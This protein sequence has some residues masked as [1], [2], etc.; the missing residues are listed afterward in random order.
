MSPEEMK[1]LKELIEQ[2]GKLTAEL[3][4]K[5]DKM[6][7]DVVHKD[8]YKK[9]EAEVAKVAKDRAELEAKHAA[10]LAE[11]KALAEEAATKASRRGLGADDDG[12]PTEAQREHKSAFLNWVRHSND[13]KA[14]AA[15]QDAEK[16]AV[17]ISTPGTGGY[18]VPEE[19]SRMIQSKV[20]NEAVMRGLVNVVSVGTSDY[21]ELVDKTG[22][23]VG[24]TGETGT[25]SETGTPA[26]YEVAPPMGEIYAY[27]KAS[28]WSLDD[29]FFNVEEWLM[30]HVGIGFATE[31]DSVVISGSGTNRP[32][33]LLNRAPVATADGARADQTLQYVPT[34]AAGAFGADEHA[35][36]VNLM[37]TLRSG[38]RR[39]ASWLMNSMTTAAVRI[40]KDGNG[41]P[42]WQ[43]NQVA[44]Q[45]PALMGHSV[46]ICEAMPDI[47]ADALAIGFG[48]WARTYTLVDRVGQRMTRDDVTQPGYV[49]F[50]VR[51]R[52]GGDVT[53]DDAAK[54]LKFALS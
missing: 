47:A 26:I 27:P 8:E 22:A 36:L 9:L 43:D 44:G 49:K 13:H 28:E 46:N 17:E 20:L 3:Q 5:F 50:Y 25:R 12:G 15:L 30:R 23:A 19:I 24:W 53:N 31:E 45:P 11:V 18:A 39:S 51:K 32:R 48:D 54:L 2:D 37:Y 4:T 21:K 35:N 52:M 41:R 34:G 10:E 42:L 14:I 29:A 1:Q 33:G 40:L 38:Y 6:T 16:K 7:A